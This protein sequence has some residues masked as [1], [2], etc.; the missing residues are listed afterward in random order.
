[1]DVSWH[2]ASSISSLTKFKIFTKIST[3]NQVNA[4]ITIGRFFAYIK[5]FLL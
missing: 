1:M 2:M 3:K 5:N 4:F